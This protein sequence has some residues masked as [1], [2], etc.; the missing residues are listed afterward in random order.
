MIGLTK[1]T[2]NIIKFS[3]FI[4]KWKSLKIR[5]F[6]SKTAHYIIT[7][8][9]LTIK[10]MYAVSILQFNLHSPKQ[11]CGLPMR[12]RCSLTWPQWWWLA[13]EY[14]RTT[15]YLIFFQAIIY[16]N[17]TIVCGREMRNFF[18]DSNWQFD[19][20]N[21]LQGGNT[22][23]NDFTS[24][25]SSWHGFTWQKRGNLKHTNLPMNVS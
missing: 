8:I 10:Q 16:S 19:I 2:I 6:R 14:I 11:L 4:F 15:F 17:Q 13:M 24:E 25:P 21:D 9:L 3:M 18:F 22:A 20:P 5:C 7:Y 12:Q 23:C 1:D